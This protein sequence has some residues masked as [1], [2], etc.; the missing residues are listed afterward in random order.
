VITKLASWTSSKG[1][2][3]I[4]GDAAHAIPPTAGQGVNQ[5]FEDVC[6]FA[7]VVDR[8]RKGAGVLSLDGRRRW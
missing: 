8:S 4:L 1:R 6:T 2:V 3:V 5:T 7:R